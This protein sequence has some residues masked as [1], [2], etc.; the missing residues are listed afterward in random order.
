[1]HKGDAHSRLKIQLSV[2]LS[3][4]YRT[5]RKLSLGNCTLQSDLLYKRQ[6][7]NLII[8]QPLS[9]CSERGRHLGRNCGN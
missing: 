2:T 6:W 4:D 8:I 9:D 5:V 3:L 7:L 1:M